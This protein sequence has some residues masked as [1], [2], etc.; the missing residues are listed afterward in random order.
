MKLFFNSFRL[1]TNYH[2]PSS[3]KPTLVQR[4]VPHDPI[5]DGLPFANMRDKLILQEGK[6]DLNKIATIL[7]TTT[8]SHDVITLAFK[9]LIRTF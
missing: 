2:L 1:D 4:T 5:I 6:V 3:L 9:L 7:V 8:V